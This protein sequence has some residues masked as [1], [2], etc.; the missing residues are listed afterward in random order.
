MRARTIWERALGP[1]HPD[2]AV[3]LA[4]LA[5]VYAAQRKYAQAEPLFVRS[6]AIVEKLCGPDAPETARSLGD[7]AAFYRASGKPKK[8]AELEKRA[9]AVRS[10]RR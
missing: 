4:N 8:A 6:L 3:S 9:A 10:A 1:E 2:V 7:L 5:E